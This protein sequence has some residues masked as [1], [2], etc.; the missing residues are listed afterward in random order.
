[1]IIKNTLRPFILTLLIGST[2]ACDS[3]S[4]S[5]DLAANS[6]ARNRGDVSATAW[7]PLPPAPQVSAEVQAKRDLILGKNAL[8]P[9]TV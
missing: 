7:T 5:N 8:D 2:A 1:M 4:S 3:S 6:A 9:S